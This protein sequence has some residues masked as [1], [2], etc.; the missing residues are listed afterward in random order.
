MDL[1]NILNSIY[2]FLLKCCKYLDISKFYIY[3]YLFA[4]YFILNYSIT[5]TQAYITNP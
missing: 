1:N 4:A 2:Q 3:I 5:L